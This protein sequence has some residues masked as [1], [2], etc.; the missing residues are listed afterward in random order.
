MAQFIA[1][2]GHPNVGCYLDLGNARSVLHGYPENWCTALNCS[3]GRPM[4]QWDTDR[5]QGEV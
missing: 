5:K 1:D 4:V 2:V 3:N